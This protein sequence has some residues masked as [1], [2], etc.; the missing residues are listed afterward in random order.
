MSLSVTNYESKTEECCPLCKLVELLGGGG[1][2]GCCPIA[3]I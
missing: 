2:G 3:S 1:G